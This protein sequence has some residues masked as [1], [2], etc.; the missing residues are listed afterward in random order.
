MIKIIQRAAPDPL[1][2]ATVLRIYADDVFIGGIRCNEVYK[3][4]S[5]SGKIELEVEYADHTT[6]LLYCDKY[7]D[8]Q[9]YVTRR[10]HE[11]EREPVQWRGQ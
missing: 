10:M 8:I 5:T 3:K 6:A 2:A 11:M 7:E 1:F 9:Q 4:K